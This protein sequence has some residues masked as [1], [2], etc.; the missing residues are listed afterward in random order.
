MAKELP[1]FKFEPAEWLAGRIL[2]EPLDVQGAYI[3]ICSIYWQKLANAKQ[4]D[5]LLRVGKQIYDLLV[6]KEFIYQKS[7]GFIG[8]KWLDEQL[9][10]RER[11]SKKRALSGKEG[12]KAKANAKQMLASAKQNLAEEKRREENKKENKKEKFTPPSLIEVKEYFREKGYTEQ[13]AERA[14]EYYTNLGWKDS[15]GKQVKSWKS[16]M[17]AVWFKDENKMKSVSG[18]KNNHISTEAMYGELRKSS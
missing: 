14:Y 13:S 16:K 5:I 6:E 18:V 11:I 1:Y 8:I 10:E 9:K 2:L 15:N 12:G 17:N 7:E 4:K 3:Y